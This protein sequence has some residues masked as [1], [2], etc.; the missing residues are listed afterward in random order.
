MVATR[1]G[2]RTIIV[3][4][5]RLFRV[6]LG[7]LTIGFAKRNAVVGVHSISFGCREYAL[8]EFDVPGHEAQAIEQVGRDVDAVDSEINC[9]EQW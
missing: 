3:E 8:I 2:E 5:L 7:N 4:S 1:L 6:T 9:A